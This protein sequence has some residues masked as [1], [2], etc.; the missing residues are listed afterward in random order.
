MTCKNLANY[1]Y[2]RIF[3]SCK[4]VINKMINQKQ[5]SQP[6]INFEAFYET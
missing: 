2:I 4:Q 5:K 1:E 6:P 3:A